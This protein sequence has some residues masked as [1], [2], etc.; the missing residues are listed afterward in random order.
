[1]PILV[2]RPIWLV[3]PFNPTAE[4]LTRPLALAMADAAAAVATPEAARLGCGNILMRLLPPIAI[5]VPGL[6][7]KVGRAAVREEGLS[8]I[9]CA[10]PAEVGVSWGVEIDI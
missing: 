6:L 8:S 10:A 5:A 4:L 2:P 1:M 9:T 3:L 7:P